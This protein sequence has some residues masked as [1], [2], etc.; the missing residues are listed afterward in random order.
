MASG[1]QDDSG[2]GTHLHA[3]DEP[4]AHGLALDPTGD[5]LEAIGS[6]CVQQHWGQEQRGVSPGV[7]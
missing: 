6:G 1:Q 7:L 5:H 2:L 3:G 4:V